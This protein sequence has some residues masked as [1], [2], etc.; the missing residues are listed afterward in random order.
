MVIMLSSK[1][2]LS[3]I[4]FFMC[5]LSLLIP[6]FELRIV[7]MLVFCVLGWLFLRAVERETCEDGGR[8]S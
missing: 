2:K 3:L 8:S 4:S 6:W 1:M 7:S 5:P